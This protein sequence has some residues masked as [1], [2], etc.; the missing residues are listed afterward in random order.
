MKLGRPKA[1]AAVLVFR[2]GL[3]NPHWVAYVPVGH[4]ISRI[5]VGL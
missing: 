4:L 5:A 1:A 3:E 2:G